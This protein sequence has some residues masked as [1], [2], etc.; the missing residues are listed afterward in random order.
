MGQL[1]TLGVAAGMTAA[2]ALAAAPASAAEIPVNTAPAGI[3]SQMFE[4]DAAFDVFAHESEVAEHH[5]WRRY[6]GYRRGWR[7][8][9][10]VGVGDIIAGAVII[11]GIAAIANS[12]SRNNERRYRDRD[13]DYRDD[14]RRDRREDRR[15]DSRYD[16]GSG[17]DNAVSQ[18]VNQ[19]ERDVRVDS[20]DS[21]D[22][23]GEGWMVQ[24][25]IYN[26]ERF[27]CRIGNDGRVTGVDYGAGFTGAS[28]EPVEDNQWSDERYAE[29]RRNQPVGQPDVAYQAQPV[30]PTPETEPQPAYPGG[31][32][33]GEQ[34]DGDLDG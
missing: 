1:K 8:H 33:P 25:A 7:R 32:L 27:T 19:I 16:G 20:V 9:R 31:P 2:C 22:R 23:T 3:T 30:R 24:G 15:G 10:R 6:R 4:Q 12:A 29:A 18:C 26:G 13:Y 5:R 11:G 17:I 34:V 28:A 14:R 21:V